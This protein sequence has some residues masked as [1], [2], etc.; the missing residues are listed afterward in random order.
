MEGYGKSLYPRFRCLISLDNPYQELPG[1]STLGKA[2][3]GLSRLIKTRQGLSSVENQGKSEEVQYFVH[4]QK[5][6]EGA[7]SEKNKEQHVV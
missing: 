2:Y 1:R 6:G 3:Q 4:E 5:V 7:R